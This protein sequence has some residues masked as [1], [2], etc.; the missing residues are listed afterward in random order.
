M[1]WSS[2][3]MLVTSYHDHASNPE[4][5]E[6]RGLHFRH[7]MRLAMA[8]RKDTQRTLRPTND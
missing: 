5:V 8:W 4:D 2:G 1:G 6:M 7:E 3:L